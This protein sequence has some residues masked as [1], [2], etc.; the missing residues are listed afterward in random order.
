[1]HLAVRVVLAE[2]V[3]LVDLHGFVL[4]V[5]LAHQLLNLFLILAID[6]VC[7][8]ISLV[9]LDVDVAAPHHIPLLTCLNLLLALVLGGYAGGAVQLD[10][11]LSLCPSF[12][13]RLVDCLSRLLLD[14]IVQ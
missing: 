7:I 12:D 10:H 3:I 5:V 1:M 6:L 2:L 13:A 8:V 4:L 11:S 9:G 14:Q